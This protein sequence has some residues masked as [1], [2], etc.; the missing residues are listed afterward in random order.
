MIW[1]SR[2]FVLKTGGLLVIILTCYVI[3]WVTGKQLSLI[4][5]DIGKLP[6]GMLRYGVINS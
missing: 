4:D 6:W 3:I 1:S 5:T 2:K